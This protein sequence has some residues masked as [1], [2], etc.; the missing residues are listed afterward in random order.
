MLTGIFIGY[1][2]NSGGRRIGLD[3]RGLTR[4]REQRR[5]RSSRQEM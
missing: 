5:V 3:D 2:L 4:H 1:A